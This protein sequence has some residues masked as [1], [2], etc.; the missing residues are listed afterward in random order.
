MSSPSEPNP[1]L[2]GPTLLG[3]VRAN[4]RR[5]IL[6][7]VATI[8][9]TALVGGFFEL[10]RP[11]GD[12]DRASIAA[13]L[14]NSSATGI[15]VPIDSDRDD[16]VAAAVRML[17]LSEAEKLRVG[18]AVRARR[19]RLGVMTVADWLD[20]DD[21]VI[22]I[23]SAGFSQATVVKLEPRIVVIPYEPAATSITITGTRDGGDGGVELAVGLPGRLTHLRPLLIG[24]SVQVGLQ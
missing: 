9:A 1:E 19:L 5:A 10:S 6:V 4:P 18:D 3:P 2:I 14:A 16:L 24:E 21:D 11:G 7:A 13:V 8:V 20:D 15:V 12:K 22:T 17:Q 23:V